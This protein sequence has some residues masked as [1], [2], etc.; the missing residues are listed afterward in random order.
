[1]WFQKNIFSSFWKINLPV[2]PSPI[3]LDKPSKPGTPE[4]TDYDNESADIRWAPSA[5]DGG[6]PITHDLIQKKEGSR[7]WEKVDSLRTPTGNEELEFKVVGLTEKTKV[8]FR[9]IAVNKGGESEPSD[10]SPTHTVKH[11]KCKFTQQNNNRIKQNID[12]Q[13]FLNT[14][15]FYGNIFFIL[16]K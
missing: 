11:R 15:H 4:I 2:W 6:S 16:L 5:S 8:Q 10:P 1:M 7:D 14:E 3:S 9:V 13:F 12:K